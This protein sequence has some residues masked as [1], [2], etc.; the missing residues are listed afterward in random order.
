MEFATNPM[1]HD[2]GVEAVEQIGFDLL[3]SLVAARQSSSATVRAM[4]VAAPQM[5]AGPIAV[6]GAS[7][8]KLALLNGRR[9][10]DAPVMGGAFADHFDAVQPVARQG[11]SHG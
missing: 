11:E 6:E 9:Q 4:T 3:R 7:T 5:P 8:S 1:E 2:A 10:S